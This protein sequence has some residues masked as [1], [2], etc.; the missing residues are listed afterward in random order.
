M[1]RL[2]VDLDD[3]ICRTTNGNYQNSDPVWPI[4]Q[5]LHEYKEKGFDIVISTS[6]NVRTFNGNIGKINANTLPIILD[7]L[8]RHNIP[9]DEIIVAK[10]WCGY[11][12]FYIDDKAVRPSEFASMSYEQIKSLLELEK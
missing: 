12:G 8:D 11:E 6:R 3:T 4:I 5:K 9:Y 1:K 2:I 10:P 7:W